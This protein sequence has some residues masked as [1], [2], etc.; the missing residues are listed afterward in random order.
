MLGPGMGDLVDRTSGI[1]WLHLSD[2]RIGSR[3][4]ALSRPDVRSLLEA[5]LRRLHSVSGP[6]DLV[7]ITNASPLP[8]PHVA[9]STLVWLWT[10]VQELGS[11]PRLVIV[12]GPH[13][14]S[15]IAS[16]LDEV[17]EVSFDVMPALLRQSSVTARFA[18]FDRFADLLHINLGLPRPPGGMFPGDGSLV[19]ERDGMRVGVLGMNSSV[20]S[21]GPGH[22]EPS[23]LIS[24]CGGELERWVARC[25]AVLLVISHGASLD[26]RSF[27]LLSLID[28][29]LVSVC[30]GGDRVATATTPGGRTQLW[31]AAPQLAVFEP[32]MFGY[33]AGRLAS[34]ARQLQARLWS[35]HLFIEDGVERLGPVGNGLDRDGASTYVLDDPPPSRA[36]AR[37]AYAPVALSSSPAAVKPQ[38]RS[39][40]WS[41][42]GQRIAAITGEGHHLVL[43]DQHGQY[44]ATV[45]A[46]TSG[47]CAVAWGPTVKRL[48]TRSRFHVRTWSSEGIQLGDLALACAAPAAMAWITPA[49]LLLGAE[50]GVHVWKAPCN[51]LAEHRGHQLPSWLL[52]PI[53]GGVLA[54]AVSPRGTLAAVAGLGG[55]RLVPLVESELAAQTRNVVTS[56]SQGERYEIVEPGV[57][58]P[59][60]R[61]IA[62]QSQDAATP[63][64]LDAEPAHAVAWSPS[65]RIFASGG[66]NG[67][68]TVWDALSRT[69][70]ARL[71]GLTDVV[72]C[73][74]FSRDGR[75]LAAVAIDGSFG[76][77]SAGD[78]TPRTLAGAR[79]ANLSAVAFHPTAD[80]I[81]LGG[82][83]GLQLQ[84]LSTTELVAPVDTV[85][86]ASAKVVLL[87]EGNVGKSCLALRLT[88]DRYEELGST[89][90]MRFWSVPLEELDPDAEI[91]P[92]ERREVVF[93]DMGGQHEY[94]LLH[95]AFLHDTMIALM[96]MEP[97]RG[98]VALRE[99][100]A[101]DQQLTDRSRIKRI[102]V[103][104]KLD[105]DCVPRDPVVVA[106]ALAEQRFTSYA[107]T[108][109][110]S[111]LG[112]AALRKAIA[113]AI[114]W[115]SV[116][117]TSRPQLFQR[118]RHHIEL[119]R[120]ARRMVL[121]YHELEDIVKQHEGADVDTA[122]IAAVVEQLAR[123]GLIADAR[124][125]T[126]ARMLIL[127]VEQIER[128]AASL[129]L[130]ARDHPRGVPALEIASVVSPDMSFPRI[131]SGERLP[132]DQELVVL[133]C[134]VDL[135]IA[136]G[137]CFR[138]NG[139]LIFPALFRSHGVTDPGQAHDSVAVAYDFLGPVEN[140]YSALVC[141]LALSQRFGAMRLWE[142]RVELARPG[143]GTAGLRRVVR[144]DGHGN[145]GRFEIFFD[146]GTDGAL[147]QFFVGVVDDFLRGEGVELVEQP[148]V[149][150]PCGHRFSEDVIRQRLSRGASDI[151][152]PVDDTWI[153]LV[154]TGDALAVPAFAA[155]IRAFRSEAL[156]TRRQVVVEAKLE[157]DDV[158][159]DRP[160]RRQAH[161]LHLSDL[162]ISADTDIDALLQPL[163]ADIEDRVEGLGDHRPDLVIVSGD[164]TNRATPQEFEAA[165][166]FLAQLLDR[167]KLTAE[168]CIVVPGNHDLSWDAR[169]YDWTHRRHLGVVDTAHHVRQGDG[170]LVRNIAGYPERFRN[171]SEQLFHPLFQRPYS[172]VPEEQVQ[173]PLFEDLGLQVLALNSAY[174]I[175]EYFPDRSAIHLGALARLLDQA[176]RFVDDAR[177]AARLRGDVLR[178]AVWHHPI[179][180]NEKIVDD[181]FVDSLVR[182]GVR[183]CLHGHVHEDRA[184]L[185]GYW[186]PTN[187]L[188]VLGAGSFGAPARERPEATPR[189]YNLVEIS[190]DRRSMRVHTRQ[191]RRSGSAWGPWC[192]WPGARPGERRAYYDV[193]LPR[194]TD[195]APQAGGAGGGGA[196]HGGGASDFAR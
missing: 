10:F 151:R 196:D 65:P 56:V 191:L 93:W 165:R 101:W 138:S 194:S 53:S 103:G 81:A 50:D 131:A 115:Q 176:E 104:S 20:Q 90:G 114:D 45:P 120:K 164:L 66:A 152:C 181:A 14:R 156:E 86:T 16:P 137:I 97:R 61:A 153:P 49:R 150:C 136:S 57:H 172:L 117:V 63:R 36:Y 106:R 118:I 75:L 9:E 110:K 109:A 31:T 62:G 85:R 180:G 5:D 186:H 33:R 123:Q 23:Q 145:A 142:H 122:A 126:G 113:D 129:I 98:E 38:I 195:P 193:E 80:V 140:I 192:A 154:R 171:F 6:W 133:E 132:R 70:L 15:P 116:T 17:N 167:C 87:G 149:V 190:A 99:L 77:W 52:S 94:R 174:Q 159:R 55:L 34:H 43:H 100:D 125:G 11:T 170:F 166:R 95:R 2:L 188:H 144:P 68:V 32:G 161:I 189:L 78:W 119:R 29:P 24:A 60:D 111:G 105:D 84:A 141:W 83:D 69:R 76:L 108:S 158:L 112:I 59:L 179:T 64:L 139:L 128:Y 19:I 71:E 1:G 25:D 91:P 13:D 26:D 121:P 143:G 72:R 107:E 89:H 82:V 183:L 44:L 178:I 185:I 47:P 187:R 7:A 28:A 147:R 169:V 48:A 146:H 39:I 21:L 102:L 18:E 27:Q 173:C 8:E 124:L 46:H 74:S 160:G 51:P 37:A 54:L 135:L 79:V 148:T 162:H 12:P 163:C 4:H 182:A 184:D 3:I 41:S 40:S 134:V 155:T 130:A 92:D 96:V 168:R 42:D 177:R 30:G 58:A 73:L 127:E 88:K 22:V 67:I 157:L 35:R 175:D